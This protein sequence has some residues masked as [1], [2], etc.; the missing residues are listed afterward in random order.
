MAGRG[1]FRRRIAA[2]RGLAVARRATVVGGGA[3]LLLD[4]TDA[5]VVR[6]SEAAYVDPRDYWAFQAQGAGAFVG[7]DVARVLADGA[8]LVEEARTNY[9][10]GTGLEGTGAQWTTT[11]SGGRSAVADP[12]GGANAARLAFGSG[13]NELLRNGSPFP[14]PPGTLVTASYYVRVPSTSRT[15]RSLYNTTIP[16]VGSGG[17]VLVDHTDWR[18][19]LGFSVDNHAEIADVRNLPS[20]EALPLDVW[21]FQLEEGPHRTSTV[22]TTSAAAARANDRIT[23]AAGDV[24]VALR[25]GVWSFTWQPWYSSQSFLDRTSVRYLLGWGS[26]AAGVTVRGVAG[27]VRVAVYRN[28]GSPAVDRTVT[29][30]AQSVLTITIDVPANE[31]T[32]E[33]FDTGDG[34]YPLSSPDWPGPSDSVHLAA[35]P[36]DGGLNADGVY[37]LPIFISGPPPPAV[38]VGDML[39]AEV[40]APAGTATPVPF[41]VGEDLALDAE[42]AEGTATALGG[43]VAATGDAL[44]AEINTPM[45]TAT[46][47]PEPVVG[48]STFTPTAYTGNR[49]A[50]EPGTRIAYIDPTL[51]SDVTGEYYYWD[52]TQVVDSATGTYGTDPF[53]PTGAIQ[54]FATATGH[55]REG[56]D[57]FT[58]TRHPDWVLMKRG[59]SFPAFGSPRNVGVSPEQP[60]LIGAYGNPADPRPTIDIASR[61]FYWTSAG[62]TR[63]SYTVCLSLDMDGRGAVSRERGVGCLIQVNPENLVG[64]PHAWHW[65]EDLRIRATRYAVEVQ[66]GPIG[67]ATVTL[68]RCYVGD[69]WDDT[70]LNQGVYCS[71][72]NP[73]VRAYDSTFYRNGY[74]VDP[75]LSSDPERNILD[76][77]FYLGGG[78]QLGAELSGIISA[79]G[80]SGGPQLR[81]GG[82]MEDSLVIEGYWFT[83]ASSNGTDAQWLAARSG[84]S[85]EFRDNVQLV[86]QND[87]PNA[88]STWGSIS[89]PGNGWI[90]VHGF[91]GRFERNIISGQVLTDLGVGVAGRDAINLEGAPSESGGVIPR[92]VTVKD[93]VVF[94]MPGLNVTGTVWDQIT[95]FEYENNVWV[96]R[97]GT[98]TAVDVA[99]G[100]A[101]ADIGTA[102]DSFSNNAF[103]TDQAAPF[104]GRDLPTWLS[105]TGVTNTGNTVAARSGAAAAEGWTAPE[106]TLRTYCED[107]LGLTVTSLTGMPEFFALAEDNRIGAWDERLTGRAVVNYIRAGFGLPAVSGLDPAAASGDAVVLETE[108]VEG[109]A[110]PGASPV[111]VSG[112]AVVLDTELAE[113]TATPGAGAFAPSDI[114]SYFA[115]WTTDVTPASG[116][117]TTWADDGGS[118]DMTAVT[119]TVQ[120][121]G[122]V[123]GLD[124]P[125]WSGVNALNRI[126]TSGGAGASLFGGD[127]EVYV[128]AQFSAI[129]GTVGGTFDGFRL[130]S[131]ANDSLAMSIGFGIDGWLFSDYDGAFGNNRALEDNGQ[132]WL[133]G[134]VHIARM[135]I[136]LSTTYETQVDGFAPDVRA[137][138]TAYVATPGEITIGEEFTGI[139][140]A[141]HVYAFSAALTA[142]Q[143]ADMYAYL[144]T[145]YPTSSTP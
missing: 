35:R 109:T 1:S 63:I 81:H 116:T 89:Q 138:P 118:H 25:E 76:R 77:N 131:D 5:T 18:N 20:G 97:N 22:R 113:G 30:S 13:T 50:N 110:T 56:G 82:V 64:D 85:F 95:G 135:T 70:A 68:N 91:G 37:T 41:L 14:N 4:I 141:V 127:F 121:G 26:Q 73:R 130:I 143:R 65:F 86:W 144:A 45:G 60:A 31:V 101:D 88:P 80:G 6:A 124:A 105:A 98:G 49:D 79:Y 123:D 59:E 8:I 39:L 36:S 132:N 10:R 129:D 93:N 115:S 125:A 137:A 69:T 16:S 133:D 106:R 120:G 51:G 46:P 33:G 54:P 38:R 53:N 83:S 34:T 3:V 52:G 27:G 48:F 139:T 2:P 47:A 145:T 29:W 122:A 40:A 107:V 102:F 103:Y 142:Q 61:S 108:L 72:D 12:I 94:E 67:D 42:L 140:G 7:P 112:D 114:P 87:T 111:A 119:G 104:D 96:D 28:A 75:T 100:I 55:L 58:G 24:P 32:L 90:F 44:V 43:P 57:G 74:P 92:D 9:N 99:S 128:V 84:S 136:E 23:W 71:R 11:A 62:R 17:D 66:A 19:R 134:N 126:Q 21:G 15:H 117:V 78:T